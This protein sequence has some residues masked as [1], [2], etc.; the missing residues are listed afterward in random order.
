MSNT[1]I[2]INEPIH[3]E[4]KSILYLKEANKK[5][6]NICQE[7]YTKGVHQQVEGVSFQYIG[8]QILDEI[9]IKVNYNIYYGDMEVSEYFLIELEK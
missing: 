5:I 6:D 1:V 9:H 7:I 2:K 3:D 4:V 8:F